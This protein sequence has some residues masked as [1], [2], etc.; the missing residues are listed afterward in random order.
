MSPPDTSNASMDLEAIHRFHSYCA[1]FPSEIAEAAIRQFTRPS[2]SIYDPFCGSGTSLTAGILLG[3]RVVGSDIDVLAGMLSGLKCAPASQL[4]Y[5]RWRGRFEARLE[6]S[7]KAIVEAWPNVRYPR[8][9]E[10]LEVGDLQLA[11][12]AFAEL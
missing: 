12:P 1:R 3:R 2:E 6:R 8:P 7:F 4:A 5:D 11:V 10:V 9:G